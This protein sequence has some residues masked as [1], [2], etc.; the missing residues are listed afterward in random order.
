MQT[1]VYLESGV[2]SYFTA[3]PSRDLIMWRDPIIEE[4]R[5]IRLPIESDCENDFDKIF[6]KAIQVQV[7]FTDRLVSR[8][9]NESKPVRNVHQVV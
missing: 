4:I 5:K 9:S 8:P 1:N 2:I 3:K 7:N 6:A